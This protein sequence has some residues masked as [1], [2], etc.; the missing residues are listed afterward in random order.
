MT[1]VEVPF[2]VA[3]RTILLPETPTTRSYF[4]YGTPGVD[5]E[6]C[7]E[8]ASGILVEFVSFMG[9]RHRIYQSY[10]A[11]TKTQKGP[12]RH[13]SRDGMS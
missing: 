11:D 4:S 5:W 9:V 1:R 12:T 8:Y 3:E 10:F 2:H 6:K 7:L 13:A